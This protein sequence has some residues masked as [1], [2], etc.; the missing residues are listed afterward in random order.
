MEFIYI[1]RCVSFSIGLLSDG[2]LK[3]YMKPGE[4]DTRNKESTLT[5]DK[6]FYR[7]Y[8]TQHQLGKD[9]FSFSHHYDEVKFL[10]RF[11][12]L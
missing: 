11:S 1:L 9:G 8:I 12:P 2:N 4:Y 10:S 7:H 5:V 3:G 6:Q